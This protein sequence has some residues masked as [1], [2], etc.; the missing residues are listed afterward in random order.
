MRSKSF[1]ASVCSPRLKCAFARLNSALVLFRS[2]LIIVLQIDR[3]LVGSSN[4][5]KQAALFISATCFISAARALQSFDMRSVW[6]NTS[7]MCLYFCKA[8]SKRFALKSEPPCSL[9][10]IASSSFSS[11]P[12]LHISC[13]L[14]VKSTHTTVNTTISALI[15]PR[16]TRSSTHFEGTVQVTLESSPLLMSQATASNASQALPLPKGKVISFGPVKP[17]KGFEPSVTLSI[18]SVTLSPSCGFS[19]SSI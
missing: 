4:C 6:F 17:G 5:K 15:S 16:P 1:S 19:C 11:P 8:S 9:R 3:Q 7:T 14:F 2:S 10:A 18:F 13:L 12:M